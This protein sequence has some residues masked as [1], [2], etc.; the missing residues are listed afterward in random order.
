MKNSFNQKQK[1]IIKTESLTSVVNFKK[2]QR[3]V[4]PTFS[5]ATTQQFSLQR[6]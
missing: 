4:G 1:D 2:S 5:K 3:K 6:L